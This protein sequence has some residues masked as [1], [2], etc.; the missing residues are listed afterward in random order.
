MEDVTIKMSEPFENAGKMTGSLSTSHQD[1]YRSL[2]APFFFYCSAFL[3]V[4]TVIKRSP[5]E[6]WQDQRK[7]VNRLILDSATMAFHYLLFHVM[8]QLNT[9][10]LLGLAIVV[11]LYLWSSLMMYPTNKIRLH[12]ICL[13]LFIFIDVFSLAVHL[14]WNLLSLNL[15]II[16]DSDERFG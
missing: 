4:L 2:F 1:L 7:M 8:M 3:C 13:R 16:V 6:I 11:F 5:N 15:F 10:F 9:I 12:F 14:F